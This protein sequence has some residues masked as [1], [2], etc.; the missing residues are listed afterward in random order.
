MAVDRFGLPVLIVITIYNGMYNVFFFYF[1][2]L[3]DYFSNSA[4]IIIILLVHSI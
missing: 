4:K 2:G 3:T 1:T